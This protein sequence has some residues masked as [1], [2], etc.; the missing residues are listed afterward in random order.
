VQDAGRGALR[1]GIPG[2]R[3]GKVTLYVVVER[4]YQIGDVGRFPKVNPLAQSYRLKTLKA[5][6]IGYVCLCVKVRKD[7]AI[8]AR[9]RQVDNVSRHTG[10][11]SGLGVYYSR[12]FIVRGIDTDGLKDRSVWDPGDTEFKVVGTDKDKGAR[13][14][15]FEPANPAQVKKPAVHKEAKAG[16]GSKEDREAA[17][18]QK[19]DFAESVMEKAQATSGDARDRLEDLARSRLEEVV[20]NY[21]GTRAAKRA[22]ELLDK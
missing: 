15:V 4:S 1:G 6:M 17:A 3:T 7:S 12:P 2:T 22:Q 19:L 5:D 20:K 10:R 16:A 21:P 13:L 14:L 11:G 9:V 18:K 8:V